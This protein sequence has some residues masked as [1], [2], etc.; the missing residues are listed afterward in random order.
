M[1]QAIATADQS[2]DNAYFAANEK[3]GKVADK[4]FNVLWHKVLPAP[5]KMVRYLGDLRNPV[6]KPFKLRKK[7]TISNKNDFQQIV[8]RLPTKI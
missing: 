4:G 6:H 8:S 1:D 7:L 3:I 5:L 2:I